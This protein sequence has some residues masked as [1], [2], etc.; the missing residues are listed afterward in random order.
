MQLPEVKERLPGQG[1]EPVSTTP[2]K[3]AAF[4]KAEI[5]KWAK[6]VQESGARVD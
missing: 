5:V 4:I 2:E 1:G 6:V 3:F